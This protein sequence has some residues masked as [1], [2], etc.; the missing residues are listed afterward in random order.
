MIKESL[1]G[2]G[3][4]HG[5]MRECFLVDIPPT[6]VDYPSRAAS[7]LGDNTWGRNAKTRQG[8]DGAV[9]EHDPLAF[10]DHVDEFIATQ[11]VNVV[12]G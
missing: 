10:I 12:V 8:P 3:R 1:A 11:V 4:G 2:G 6:V 7:V 5:R 9:G